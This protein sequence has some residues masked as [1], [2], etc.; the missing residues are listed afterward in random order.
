MDAAFGTATEL[1]DKLKFEFE[2]PLEGLTLR[3]LLALVFEEAVA[4]LRDEA[5]SG[6]V[7]AGALAPLAELDAEGSLF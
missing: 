4:R 3:L 6:G 1:D 2:E 7:V 5:E